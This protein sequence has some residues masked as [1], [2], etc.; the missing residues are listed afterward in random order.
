MMPAPK[1]RSGRRTRVLRCECLLLGGLVLD[2]QRVP[3]GRCWVRQ[4]H[5][6][7]LLSWAAADG[8]ARQRE[9]SL[10]WLHQLLDEGML[11]RVPPPG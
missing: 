10:D 8:A 5:Q 7:A 9:I 6:V 11:Q 3:A 4:S 1:P 2:G